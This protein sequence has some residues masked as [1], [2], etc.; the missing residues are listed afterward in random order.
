[1]ERNSFLLEM[2]TERYGQKTYEIVDSQRAVLKQIALTEMRQTK[3]QI[4]RAI[5]KWLHD[6]YTK[7]TNKRRIKEKGTT[8]SHGSVYSAI[9]E[10][11]KEYAIVGEEKRKYFGN[12]MNEYSLTRFGVC[13]AILQLYDYPYEP[14][15]RVEIGKIAEN[16]A[17]IDPA[18]FG[19]W[20]LFKQKF[21]KEVADS[22]ILYV[23]HLGVAEKELDQEEFREF[24]VNMLIEYI[25]YIRDQYN[26]SKDDPEELQDFLKHYGIKNDVNFNPE[27]T[28]DM[29]LGV[30]REDSDLN[31]YLLSY[32]DYVFKS[33]EASL[34][35]GN[36]LKGKMQ[37]LGGGKHD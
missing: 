1:M 36:F 27:S 5:N 18:L 31:K 9:S 17:F 23:A 15:D 33:A 28:L 3:I 4:E 7:G 20:K 21:G 34:E 16:W 35:W 22:F 8:I 14:K 12:P 19:K 30:I 25:A 11:E 10:L 6:R 13:L 2:F 26:A 29:W 24:V 32:I 37:M